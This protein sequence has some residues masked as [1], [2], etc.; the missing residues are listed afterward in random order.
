[1]GKLG[2]VRVILIPRNAIPTHWTAP[3][4]V[5]LQFMMRIWYPRSVLSTHAASYSIC[6]HHTH[7]KSRRV[8]PLMVVWLPVPFSVNLSSL[9]LYSFMHLV[10]MAQHHCRFSP[11]GKPVVTMQFVVDPGW[12]VQSFSPQTGETQGVGWGPFC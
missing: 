12:L 9:S 1:L 3:T 2:T 5:K 7:Y 10:G 4:G 8:N 11:A 6:M